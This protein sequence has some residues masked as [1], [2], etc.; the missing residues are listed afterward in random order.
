MLTTSLNDHLPRSDADQA[1]VYSAVHAAQ[2][3]GRTLSEVFAVGPYKYTNL[4][5]AIAQANRDRQIA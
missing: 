2:G 5:D 4:K 1:D 3:I